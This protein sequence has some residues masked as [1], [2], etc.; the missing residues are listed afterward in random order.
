[1]AADNRRKW[2][3]L[4]APQIMRPNELDRYLPAVT[5][6]DAPPALAR[7]RAFAM[8][9]R[10]L[11][12]VAA[13]IGRLRTRPG[14][15]DP[16]VPGSDPILVKRQMDRQRQQASIRVVGGACQLPDGSFAFNAFYFAEQRAV[17]LCYSL[18]SELE[19]WSRDIVSQTRVGQ[20]RSTRP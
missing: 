13:V 14:L 10:L 19:Q 18:V 8:Q 12:R 5:Y 15:V 6:E 7:G 3:A 17:L 9:H 16:W 11:E 4:L 2:E 1:M 20:G